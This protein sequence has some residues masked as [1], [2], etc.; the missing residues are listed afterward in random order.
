MS[1][2]AIKKINLPS[3]EE[4]LFTVSGVS[5]Y[6]D[7][8]QNAILPELIGVSG[9]VISTLVERIGSKSLAA[10]A[11][12]DDLHLSKRT[13]QRHLQHQQVCFT[14]LRDKVRLNYVLPLLVENELSID[15]LSA[16]LDF[17]DRTSFT[18]AFK[19]WTGLSPN[20]F[21]K[22]FRDYSS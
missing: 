14:D 12:A 19:R 10:D 7:F 18:L 22:L 17:T 15:R 1:V 11:I 6:E 16:M 5:S 4:Q 9:R 3:N 13:L 2:V 20:A 21:R 8:L